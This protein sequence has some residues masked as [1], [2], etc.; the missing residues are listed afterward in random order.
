VLYDVTDRMAT[1]TLNR[2]AK[3]NAMNR[4]LPEETIEAVEASTLGRPSASASSRR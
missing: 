4:L 2:P 1:I 3:L